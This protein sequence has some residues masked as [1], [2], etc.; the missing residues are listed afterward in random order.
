[1]YTDLQSKRHCFFNR[2]PKRIRAVLFTKCDDAGSLCYTLASAT[3]NWTICMTRPIIV[4]DCVLQYHTIGR[5]PRRVAMFNSPSVKLLRNCM[6]YRLLRLPVSMIAVA[7]YTLQSG[8]LISITSRSRVSLPFYQCRSFS[9][10]FTSIFRIKF[11]FYL[12]KITTSHLRF[13][14]QP[15]SYIT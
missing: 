15:Q 2:Y 1:V 7:D 5:R 4:I 12:M 13:N 14:R 10:Q 11:Q 6:L 8:L 9:S 3:A